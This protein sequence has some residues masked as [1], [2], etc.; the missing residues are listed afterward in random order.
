MEGAPDKPGNLI[1]WRAESPYDELRRDERPFARHLA[2]AALSDGR[3]LT[4]DR[5]ALRL[6]TPRQP[7]ADMSAPS[8]SLNRDLS[9]VNLLALIK[10]Y[11]YKV[12]D[13][14]MR[15]GALFSPKWSGSR[16]EIPYAPPREY[17]IDI[18]VERVGREADY[19][20][21]IGCVVDGRQIELSIDSVIAQTGKCTGLHGF[22]GAPLEFGPRYHRG[23]LL[24][25]D[26]KSRLELTV[27]H[28]SINL[29]C[30]GSNVLDWKGDPTRF[31]PY[32]RRW[33]IPN[34]DRLFLASGS[35]VKFSEMTL[36]PLNDATP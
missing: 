24:F 4:G 17:R 28:H 29:K 6:W 13:W 7:G 32:Y 12:N 10:P 11:S 1:V 18:K 35:D 16:L 22:D 27:R 9:P 36:T 5:F 34:R 21:S 26:R 19:G 15:A 23:Q 8:S 2:I 33:N 20:F 14:P 30:D 3:V 25:Q 31:I